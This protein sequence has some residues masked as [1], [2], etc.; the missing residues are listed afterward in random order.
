MR[1]L[2]VAAALLASL[3]PALQDSKA[4]AGPEVGKP[5]PTAR[6]NNHEGVVVQVGGKSQHWTILAFFPRAA[7]P[8]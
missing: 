3:S 8:G 2:L 6:L 1:S 7:T 4:K 5:A